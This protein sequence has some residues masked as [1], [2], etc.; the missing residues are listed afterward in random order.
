V[1]NLKQ[2]PTAHIFNSMCV[3]SSLRH[4][5]TKK[6]SIRP[7]MFNDAVIVT[8]MVVRSDSFVSNL[9]DISPHWCPVELGV[10]EMGNAFKAIQYGSE[11][12][13]LI[14]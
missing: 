9:K 12:Q 6:D 5:E 8:I 7:S 4:K 10:S 13:F 11:T 3:F 1:K 14:D 2:H